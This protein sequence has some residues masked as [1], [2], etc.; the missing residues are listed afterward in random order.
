M[1][2]FVFKHIIRLIKLM[3]F[4]IPITAIGQN[5]TF[6]LDHCKLQFN[7]TFRINDKGLAMQLPPCLSSLAFIDSATERIEICLFNNSKNKIGIV[8]VFA[9]TET[10]DYSTMVKSNI[11]NEIIEYTIDMDPDLIRM[12]FSNVRDLNLKFQE[13]QLNPKVGI[14]IVLTGCKLHFP[15]KLIFY[16]YQNIWRNNQEFKL[17]EKKHIA[18]LADFG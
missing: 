9:F 12:K 10:F 14:K 2:L 1:E 13:I 4:L 16:Y 5:Q 3:L 6:F 17:I 8:N 18:V 7:D 11:G 15:V